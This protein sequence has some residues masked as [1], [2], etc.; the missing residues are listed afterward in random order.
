MSETLFSRIIDREIPA[1]IVYED[2]D[3]LVVTDSR[4][5]RAGA[6]EP[7]DAVRELAES[8]SRPA[9][10]HC[11]VGML[12]LVYAGSQWLTR[13]LEELRSLAAGRADQ[14]LHRRRRR[15]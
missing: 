12:V 13:S 6:V 4:H 11:A 10:V 1:D 5:Q 2:D 8:D 14:R 3:V 9:L 7:E 15:P